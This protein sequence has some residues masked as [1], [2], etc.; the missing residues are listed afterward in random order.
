MP[1][2]PAILRQHSNRISLFEML[3]VI[4]RKKFN[5]TFFLHF[6]RGKQNV[7]K[8]D[9]SQKKEIKEKEVFEEKKDVSN[10]NQPIPQVI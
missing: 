4:K 3:Q 8:P 7:E 6:N 9:S 2:L 1:Q 10:E 5:F